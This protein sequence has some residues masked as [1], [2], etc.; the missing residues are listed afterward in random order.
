MFNTTF[1][2][3]ANFFITFLISVATFDLLPEFVLPIFFDFPVKPPFNLAFQACGYGNMYSIMNLGT[4]FFLFNIYILQMIF[5]CIMGVFRKN[6]KF[7]A[8]CHAKY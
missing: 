6:S 2:A 1:P 3:N 8:G 5:Y 4:C 7:A